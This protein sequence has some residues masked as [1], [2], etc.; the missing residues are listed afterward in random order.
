VKTVYVP[1]DGYRLTV[2][3]EGVGPPLL[4]CHSLTFDSTMWAD[5]V[6]ALSSQYRVLCLDL[7]GHGASG[8][9]MRE[10]TLEQMAE[11]LL[12]VL[13]YLNVS[14][15]GLVGHSM[16]GM[17]AMRFAMAHPG[18]VTH[19]ALLNTSAHAQ[20]EPIRS[21]FHQ[22]NEESRGKPTNSSTVDF[23][24]ELMF[25]RRFM[26]E[27][28][29]RV[30][31]FRQMLAQAPEGDGTYWAARAVIW[32]TSVLDELPKIDVPT[33]VLCS[34][35]DTSVPPSH[36]VAIAAQVAHSELVELVGPGHLTP[37]EEPASVTSA[38]RQHLERSR[39]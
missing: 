7:H 12:T 15:C 6:N 8:H 23:V 10:H 16:G 34:D 25:S 36:S 13:D 4:F 14:E 18:R 35:V 17:V 5:Q 37:V 20:G 11:D 3:E 29:A 24:M 39:A 31:P 33:L 28:P 22:V 9:P 19:L 27:H 30:A 21:L 1:M 2:Y 38:L 26:D 32:R